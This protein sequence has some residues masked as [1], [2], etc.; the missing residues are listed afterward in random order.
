MT[1][2][3]LADEK[4]IFQD[5]FEKALTVPDC[6]VWN[7]NKLGKGNGEAKF[8]ISSNEDAIKRFFGDSGFKATCFVLKADLIRYL[9]E[10]H[11]EY[12]NPSLKYRS[13]SDLSSLWNERMSMVQQYPDIIEFDMF[14]QSQIKGGRGYINTKIMDGRKVL[15]QGRPDGYKILRQ[16]AL[17]LVSYISIMKLSTLDGSILYYW[18]LFADFDA[19]ED[20]QEA[21]VFNYGQKNKEDNTIPTPQ[22]QE[23]ENNIR[24]A[25]QGQ[26]KYRE[27]LLNLCP[28]CPITTISDERL[29]IASHIKPWRDCTDDE[30]ID[31]INGLA[32][33]PMFDRLFDQGYITFTEDRRIK[34]SCWLS[35]NT[36]KKIGIEDGKRYALL[37][38]DEPKRLQYMEYHQNV[39]FKG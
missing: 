39:I 16:L 22:E 34:L 10:I 28:F 14:D 21:L 23:R 15:E 1:I 25:R 24:K 12:V 7:T 35:N 27:E 8:Y 33:S 20:K 32:L 37:P 26:G 19:I 29:L 5:T 13:A 38:F 9:N 11:S 6:V 18:K 2:I 17:P 31:P 4:F 3:N 36:Y 30:K